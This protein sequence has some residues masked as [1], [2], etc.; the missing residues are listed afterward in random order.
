MVESEIKFL[1][2]ELETGIKRLDERGQNFIKDDLV[3]FQFTFL[4]KKGS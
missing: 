4:E 1:F 2:C 3:A